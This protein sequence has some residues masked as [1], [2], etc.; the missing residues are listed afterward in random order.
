[1]SCGIGSKT[2]QRT[3]VLTK[4]R[5]AIPRSLPKSDAPSMS[6][7]LLRLALHRPE[8][9]ISNVSESGE[10]KVATREKGSGLVTCACGGGGIS[11]LGRERAQTTGKRGNTRTAV[12]LDERHPGG[13]WVGSELH[14]LCKADDTVLR[15]ER[16]RAEDQRMR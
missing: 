3:S 9:S 13:R 5:I 10:G 6:L 14:T 15:A 7:S 12:S 1:M 11:G 16:T 4:P 2:E 8:L